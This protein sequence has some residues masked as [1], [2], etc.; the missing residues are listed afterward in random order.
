MPLACQSH[1][2]E[3]WR[4]YALQ[5]PASMQIR[6]AS[7]GREDI[8]FAGWRRWHLCVGVVYSGMLYLILCLS[9]CVMCWCGVSVVVSDTSVYGVVF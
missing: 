8:R 1:V 6:M 2:V 5:H 4:C 9:V 7:L 3:V